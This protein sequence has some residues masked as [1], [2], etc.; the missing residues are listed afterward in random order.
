MTL[1]F[2]PVPDLASTLLHLNLRRTVVQP[3]TRIEAAQFDAIL[4]GE[5]FN[6]IQV[7][8]NE[9]DGSAIV[10]VWG[11]TVLR[12]R[13][14]AGMMSAPAKRG[15]GG[16]GLRHGAR[17]AH[18]HRLL[19]QL[20][21]SVFKGTRACVGI[22]VNK[23]WIAQESIEFLA[24]CFVDQM[25]GNRVR[26]SDCQQWYKVSDMGYSDNGVCRSCRQF[27]KELKSLAKGQHKGFKPLDPPVQEA[28]PAPPSVPDPELVKTVEV[29]NNHNGGSDVD[30]ICSDLFEEEPVYKFRKR[31]RIFEDEY[32]DGKE[33]D[34]VGA[35][36]ENGASND[37]D[38]FNPDD[39]NF[40]DAGAKPDALDTEFRPAFNF[41][42][43]RPNAERKTRA[44][45]YVPSSDTVKPAAKPR[46]P[47]PKCEF[48]PKRFY[49]DEKLTRHA[50]QAHA[51]ATYICPFCDHID[52]TPG[53][54]VEHVKISHPDKEAWVFAPCCRG[55]VLA[56]ELES[57][58]LKCFSQV[59]SMCPKLFMDRK[60]Q[61]RHKRTAH[62]FWRHKCP[63][64]HF[65]GI[66]PKDIVR[67]VLD[68]HKTEA[69]EE[70]QAP[71]PPPDIICPKCRL[72]FHPNSYEDHCLN[73]K[74]G[75]ATCY[76]SWRK[77]FVCFIC[78]NM[79]PSVSFSK[80]I[81]SCV[82]KEKTEVNCPACDEKLDPKAGN[83]NTLR[84]HLVHRHSCSSHWCSLCNFVSGLP[85]DL[86]KHYQESHAAFAA[87]APHCVE[88]PKCGGETAVADY[89]AHCA[90]CLAEQSSVNPQQSGTVGGSDASSMCDVCGKIFSSAQYMATHK[91][92]HETG[93]F[94]CNE[95]GVEFDTEPKLKRHKLVHIK[96]E[97][98]KFCSM[99][100]KT[101]RGLK[102]HKM[103]CK[104]NPDVQQAKFAGL[105]ED[106]AAGDKAKKRGSLCKVCRAA[107]PTRRRRL[108]HQKFE[109]GISLPFKCDKCDQE[110]VEKAELKRH[111]EKYHKTELEELCAVSSIMRQAEEAEERFARWNDGQS[112]RVK[113][114]QNQVAAAP[115]YHHNGY[116]VQAQPPIKYEEPPHPPPPPVQQYNWVEGEGFNVIEVTVDTTNRNQ[117]IYD[118]SMPDL[119]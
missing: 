89:E 56:E 79:V 29:S 64:C 95:C 69:T 61:V 23:C 6:A 117:V 8:Y 109:H 63:L 87:I 102:K 80:H 18:G 116:A 101:E 22:K 108:H 53:P 99:E 40:V 26:S 44:R 60:K 115:T 20:C 34:E 21:W 49:D 14:R 43:S 77:I 46:V 37:D 118:R 38:D 72:A 65:E 62:A 42:R 47:L 97:P 55:F 92:T 13:L 35:P 51:A 52:K 28:V 100:F 103:I 66:Q 15:G 16:G 98:C 93:S 88:C 81:S 17:R 111:Q 70:G 113:V 12:T 31:K 85:G 107:F 1:N 94:L 114:E 33:Y 45:H 78:N 5:P 30:S 83:G 74:K 4:S 32:V 91:K 58:C 84:S 36:A 39:E 57:H 48:C 2:D 71:P 112:Q 59:C 73:Q 68:F 86:V 67:H 104:K 54:L 119:M 96:V 76:S 41:I 11:R 75:Q 10:R 7:F 90:T 105:P 50:R 24:S 106:S 27:E 110:Y 19:A 25:P 9:L 82:G 3:W